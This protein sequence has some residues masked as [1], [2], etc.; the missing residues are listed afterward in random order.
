M[1]TLDKARL[2]RLLAV[3]S[4][5]TTYATMVLGGYVK[6]TGAGLACPDWPLCYG[7]VL[8]NLGDPLILAEWAHRLV[9]ALTSLFLILTMVLALLWFRA[10][11]RYVLLSSL[12]VTCLLGQVA[13]G[14]L[15]ITSRLDPLVV[16]LHL[17]IAIATFAGALAL[18]VVVLVVPRS[19]SLGEGVHEHD[20]HEPERGPADPVHPVR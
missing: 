3:L 15:T 6:A 7:S 14:A 20:P 12:T 16:T 13:L 2:F 8:P 4:T 10:E 18:A 11:R 19:A 9:A 1:A 5:F 17:G